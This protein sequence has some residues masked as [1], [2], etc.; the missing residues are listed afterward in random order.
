VPM[1]IRFKRFA[2][3]AVSNGFTALV[4]S[5]SQGSFPLLARVAWADCSLCVLLQ[6]CLS[7][8]YLLIIL[9]DSIVASCILY[10]VLFR[11]RTIRLLIN[12]LVLTGG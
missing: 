2:H 10:T 7:I 4:K 8:N 11:L 6:L 12:L 5:S 1:N 9:C 3:I